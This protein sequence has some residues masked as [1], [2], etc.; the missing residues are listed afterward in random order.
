MHRCLKYR[1]RYRLRVSSPS[2]RWIYSQV[3]TTPTAHWLAVEGVQPSVAQNPSHAEAVRLSEGTPKGSNATSSLAATAGN[4]DNVSIKPL[5]K[6][7][8]SKELQLYYERVCSAIT[9]ESNEI[10]RNA[11]LASLRNDPGLHQLLPYFLQFV[12]ERVT[13]KLK[14]MFVLMQMMD[15]TH[16][17]LENENLFI[18]PYVRFPPSS[19]CAI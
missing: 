16:A 18:E 6:H 19:L 9:D 11:A 8:L 10:A 5:V 7:V 1:G 4:S 15:L 3:L 2:A 12:S 17:L 13:H 14:D